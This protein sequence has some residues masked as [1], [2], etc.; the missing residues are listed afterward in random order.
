MLTGKL[1][2]PDSAMLSLKFQVA[3]YVQLVARKFFWLYFP[4]VS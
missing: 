2:V 1:A 4:V 3:G